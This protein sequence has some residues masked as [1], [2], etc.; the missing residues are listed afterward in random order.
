MQSACSGSLQDS[1][2]ITVSGGI[3]SLLSS[4][5]ATCLGNDATLTVTPDT[6]TTS[7]PWNMQL[8]DANGNIILFQN[9]VW[10]SHTFTNLFPGTYSVNL[11]EPITGCSGVN[12]IVVKQVH[13]DLS[14]SAFSANVSCF[15]GNDGYI[16]V[17]AD[18]GYPPYQFFIDG[19]F[20]DRKSVV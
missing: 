15:D 12:S 20:K 18:S 10:S 19:V 3:T 6:N 7:P 8:M 13:I 5:D 4:I 2:T 1:V 17:Y 9:N 11:V 16:S 14:F